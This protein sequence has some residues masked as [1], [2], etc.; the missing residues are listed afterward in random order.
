MKIQISKQVT[1][2][3][4]ID[5]PAFYRIIKST[6]TEYYYKILSESYSVNFVLWKDG[7]FS[8]CNYDSKVT[9]REAITDGTPITEAE[10]I[11]AFH[12]LQKRMY[13]AAEVPESHLIEMHHEEVKEWDFSDAKKIALKFQAI[14]NG[15][16]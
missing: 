8:S 7:A 16:D 3:I 6:E 13:L 4:T 10:F 5:V 11:T 12:E 9:V 2:E 15:Q 1:E 14:A